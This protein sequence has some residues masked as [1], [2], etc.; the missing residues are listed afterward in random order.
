MPRKSKGD[1]PRHLLV[2]R[3]S[4][5]GDV[6]MLAHAVRALKEACPSLRVTIATQAL[7]QPFFAGLDVEFLTADVKGAHHSLRG[8][9][10]LA[11]EARRL[12]VD[13]VADVHGTL[14]SKTFGLSMRLR[15][16]RVADIRK[17]RDEKRA[18]IRCGGRGM[19]P[20][21]HTVLRYC[22]VFRR[23]GFEFEDP[24]PARPAPRPNPFG[25][26]AG[27]WIGFAP[28]SAQPGK[29]YPE[30][31]AREVVDLLAAQYE[32]VFIHSG[33]GTEAE[34]AREMERAYPNVTALYGKVRLA[35]EMDLI[36]HL[37][38]VVSMDSLVMHLASLVATPVVSVWGATHPGLGFLGYGS[39]MDHVLQADMECRPCSVFG[40]R[41]CRYGDY[42]CMAA[43][44]PAQI[45][46]AVEKVLAGCG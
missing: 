11:A 15:G 43:V 25:S 23:L 18:F 46:A 30:T 8:I 24:R 13:A 44:S 34:L 16:I 32:R 29:T 1:L 33:G 2:F 41:P 3:T 21:R 17:G 35:G 20:L 31:Q 5:M 38:C 40:N 7:F 19:E 36:S 28:F 39:S 27:R 42:R 26:K 22:D 9:W 4:A 45:V 14:R 10:R 12:G 37:D 6:A